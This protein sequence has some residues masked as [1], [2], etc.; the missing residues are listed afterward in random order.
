MNLAYLYLDHQELDLAKKY[1]QLRYELAPDGDEWGEFLCNIFNEWYPLDIHRVSVRHFDA[2]LA[3][4]VD[5]EANVCS[6]GRNCR[7][8]F[9][10]EHNGDIFPCDFFVERELRLGNVNDTSWQK[11]LNSPTYREFG[12]KKCHWNQE[13]QTCDC[14]TASRSTGSSRGS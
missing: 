11:A 10:V 7:R 3:K 2:I 5:G 12:E 4:I 9:V 13:C 1:F 8:Y 14:L 6:L